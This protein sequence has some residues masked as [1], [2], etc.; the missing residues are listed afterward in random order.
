MR[1]VED[2]ANPYAAAPAKILLR[3]NEQNRG[4]EVLQRRRWLAPASV[5]RDEEIHG[6]L[7]TVS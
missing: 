3:A 1:P 6:H 7:E 4:L 2:A 5:E